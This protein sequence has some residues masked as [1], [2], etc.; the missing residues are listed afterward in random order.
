MDTGTQIFQM[1]L[2][3]NK[4]KEQ[5]IVKRSNYLFFFRN[6]REVIFLARKKC[7]QHSEKKLIISE[8]KSPKIRKA[9]QGA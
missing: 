6:V 8:K 3:I 2:D 1:K 9:D 5:I 4:R 7:K